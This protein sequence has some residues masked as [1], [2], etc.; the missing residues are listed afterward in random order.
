VRVISASPVM[1]PTRAAVVPLLLL[2][3]L[4]LPGGTGAQVGERIPPL[5]STALLSHFADAQGLVPPSF[6][7]EI[8]RRENQPLAPQEAPAKSAGGGVDVKVN[9][10][11]SQRP[12]NETAIVVNPFSPNMLVAGANDYRLGAPIGAAFYTSFDNGFSWN[13]GVP[14]YPLLVGIQNGKQKVTE[15]PFGTGDPVLAFGR[16]REGDPELLAGTPVVYYAYLGVSSSFCEHGLFVSRSSNGLTWTRPAVPPLLPPGG[17]FTP[18]YWDSQNDC[19]VFNDKPWL[20][21]DTSGGPHDGRVYV[22]WSRFTFKHGRFRESP[23][24]LAYSD[25][26][27]VN[28]STPLEVSGFSQELCEAQV[29][30]PKGRCDESH[31]SNVRVGPDGRVYVAFVNQQFKGAEDGFRNQYLLTSVDPDSLAVSGPFRA[32]GLI[33]GQNDLPLN[34]LDQPTICNS[35]FR[36]NTFGNIALDPSDPM[37]KTLYLVFADNRNGSSFP[38]PT[39]VTQQPPDSFLCPGGST[40]D[41][42]IFIVKST[43]GG[44]TWGSPAGGSADP[45]RV[46]QDTVKNGHDQWF[47]F[48]Q[49]GPG[50]RVDV[51]FYDRRDDFFNRLAHVYLAR[52]GDGGASWT[53]I[54]VTDFPSNM[55]WAFEDGLFIGDYNGLAI[56]PD[57]TS[58]PFWTDARRGTPRGRQSDVMLDTVRP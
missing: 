54:R 35:N 8:A 5:S 14:P 32:A 50:G 18:V 52:S 38:H 29:S 37:G 21:V 3:L 22:T 4:L 9:Q 6:V 43:D 11:F 53:E 55:N 47:P 7:D 58:Y 27:G 10:D 49:V 13:D 15:P 30:G 20:A 31:F 2:I 26:N 46:N 16:A 45:L 51:M 36:F 25:D 19:S 42:D 28:W 34:S 56:A 44:V 12:Q 24:F 17:A 33:D 39:R 41:T 48:V 1:P 23:I 57:G 40:T